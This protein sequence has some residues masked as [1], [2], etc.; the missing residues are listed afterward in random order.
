MELHWHGFFSAVDGNQLKPGGRPDQSYGDPGFQSNELPALITHQWLYRARQVKG[1]F[2]EAD[3][4][5]AWMTEQ[6]TQNVAPMLTQRQIDDALAPIEFRIERA[7]TEL[8][9]G[10]DIIWGY[11][12]TNARFASITMVCCPNRHGDVPCPAGSR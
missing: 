6:Y 12:L 10:N 3:K 1:T 5:V 7:A 2:R 9:M 8:P 4:A 11:W